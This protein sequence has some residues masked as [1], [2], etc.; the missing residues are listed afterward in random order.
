MPRL[1]RVLAA[2]AGV[3]LLSVGTSAAGDDSHPMQVKVREEV[4]VTANDLRAT[5]ASNSPMLVADPV[6]SKRLMI[7]NRLDAPD[8]SC[9]LQLSGDEGRSWTSTRPVPKLPVGAEKCYAAEVAF[10]RSGLIYFLFI[11]LHGEGNSP[12]GTFIATSADGGKTFGPPHPALGPERYQ[13]HMVIDPT[14][15]RH[16][17]LHLVWLEASTAAPL[18][19]LPSPPNPIMSAHSDDGGTT[20]SSPVQVSD[21][22]RRL[23]VAPSVVLGPGHSVYVIYYDLGNDTRDYQGLEGPVWDGRWSLVLARSSDA[24]SHFE[25]MGVV[26]DQLVPAQRIMLIYTMPP[27]SMAVDAASRIFVAWD[28]A[29]NG[30]RDA[31]V[32]RSLDGGRTWEQLERINDDQ[33]GNGRTQ[34]MPHIAL[35]PTQRLDIIFYDRRN[36]PEDERN[37]VYYAFSTD[38]G[39][40][41]GQ[42]VKLTSQ[43]SPSRSGQRYPIPSAHGLV[44]FGSRLALLGGS[45]KVIA[46]WT[47]S[48]NSRAEPYQDVFATRVELQASGSG[49]NHAMAMKRRTI[50]E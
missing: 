7:A 9:A 36:D 8:F 38:G 27:A 19:G 48:R 14:I 25:S 20:F 1:T 40:T 42:N 17:R 11:G 28:D 31:F 15:G 4:P 10:D 33:I 41:F 12:M 24:G 2:M 32:R 21:P 39:V 16:G 18:G 30:D 6:H 3:T 22:A 47:D 46:A 5:R 37:D 45:T 26:D 13:V 23:S 43:S 49:G 29:R 44:E 34:Y 50:E 35:A